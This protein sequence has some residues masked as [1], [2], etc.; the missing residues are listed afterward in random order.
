MS[1]V[2]WGLSFNSLIY[3]EP[4][5]QE[6]VL[7]AADEQRQQ[8]E[9]NDTDIEFQGCIAQIFSLMSTVWQPIF[10]R[11]GSEQMTRE[12]SDHLLYLIISFCHLGKSAEQLFAEDQNAFMVMFRNTDEELLTS[13]SIRMSAVDFFDESLFTSRQLAEVNQ[14]QQVLE[15]IYTGQ[16]PPNMIGT[17]Q[18][19]QGMQQIE[20]IQ[21]LDANQL[22]FFPPTQQA[23][24]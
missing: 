22:I 1:R 17:P 7:F 20:Q 15:A 6:R 4:F 23:Q 18:K 21:A 8:A 9:L 5:Y 12:Q 2:A 10:G 16:I 19:F 3:L 14:V 13:I 11:N 24:N